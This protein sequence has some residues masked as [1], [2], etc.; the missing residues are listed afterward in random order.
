MR[1]AR[2]GRDHRPAGFGVIGGCEALIR[3]SMVVFDV[4]PAVVGLWA[5]LAFASSGTSSM[6]HARIS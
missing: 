1:A 2:T 6:R 4:F 5:D 3:R